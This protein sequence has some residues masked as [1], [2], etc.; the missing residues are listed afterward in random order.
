MYSTLAFH[1]YTCNT[2]SPY[3]LTACSFPLLLPFPHSSLSLIPPFPSFLLFPHSSRSLIP[4]VPSFLPFPH[5]SLSLIPPVPSFLP[6]PHSFLSLIPPVPSFLPFPHFSCSLIPPFPSFL[7]FP[8]SSLPL[9]SSLHRPKHRCSPLV[10]AVLRY[11]PQTTLQLLPFLGGPHLAVYT[12][13]IF[14][15]LGL[16]TG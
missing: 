12:S 14:R 3:P 16:D 10:P 9:L 2:F 8:H 1:I 7:P 4:P 11:V 5:S 6:F 13:V 15:S